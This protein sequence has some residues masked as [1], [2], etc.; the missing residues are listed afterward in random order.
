MNCEILTPSTGRVVPRSFQSKIQR[1]VCL[2]STP[3]LLLILGQLPAGSATISWTNTA[4]GAWEVAAN[5]DANRVPASSDD[6]VI[7]ANGNYT[8]TFNNVGDRYV[9]S[10]TIGGSSGKQQLITRLG[11]LVLGGPSFVNE[12]GV[13]SL[14]DNGLG[15][16]GSMTVN[17]VF[18]WNSGWIFIGNGLTIASSG[19]MNITNG[20]LGLSSVLKNHGIVNWYSGNPFVKNDGAGDNGAIWNEV[21]GVWNIFGDGSISRHH[22]AEQFHNAGLVRKMNSNGTSTFNIIFDNVGDVEAQSGV[23]RFGNGGSFGGHFVAEAGTSIGLPLLNFSASADGNVIAS[24]ISGNEAGST[25]VLSAIPGAGLPFSSWIVTNAGGS[26]ILSVIGNPAKFICGSSAANV[27]AHFG[28][29]STIMVDAGPGGSVHATPT[30]GP[31]GTTTT[32]L[33]TPSPGFAFLSW[34]P[35]NLGGGSISSTTANPVTFTFGISNANV[36]AN[37]SPVP[38]TKTG[39]VLPVSDFQRTTNATG[40]VLIIHGWTPPSLPLLFGSPYD[41]DAAMANL[42]IEIANRFVDDGKIGQWDVQLLDWSKGSIFNSQLTPTLAVMNAVKRG[43]KEANNIVV[44]GYSEVHL[45]GHSAGV[46]LADSIGKRLVAKGIPVNVTFLDAFVP[47]KFWFELSGPITNWLHDVYTPDKLGQGIPN[48]EHYVNMSD[49]SGTDEVLPNCVNFD[50]TCVKP[51]AYDSGDGHGWPVRWYR[52]TVANPNYPYGFYPAGVRVGFQDA[53]DI[54]GSKGS[55]NILP[56]GAA[57]ITVPN[58]TATPNGSVLVFTNLNTLSQGGDGN[59]A[60]ATNGARLFTTNYIWR[61]FDVD[62]TNSFNLGALSLAFSNHCNS[63]LGLW[64]DGSP[65][66]LIQSSISS[67]LNTLEVFPLPKAF[68][69]GAH[70]LGVSLESLDGE[71]VTVTVEAVGFYYTV[72]GPLVA[73]RALTPGKVEINWDAGEGLKYQVQYCDDLSTTNWL[74]LGPTVTAITNGVLSASENISTNTQR[75]YRVVVVP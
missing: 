42:Q 70:T 39:D 43:E 59:S 71:A 7:S 56:P 36:T 17:G 65:V 22:G 46:W 24:S 57:P 19:R 21:G 6:V 47:S 67:E 53:F 50:I 63:V 12:N 41:G 75:F 27:V 3:L 20:F 11:W 34:S 31:A 29:P 58:T 4:G 40:L 16:T 44:K 2:L 30:A 72:A 33:A 26:S 8:V 18:N 61:L 23:V 66:S 48:A 64:I 51:L 15:G 62:V 74:S 49:L 60:I 10:L 55:R 1:V 69:S 37:F 52:K 32:L 68:A 5:W 54:Q 35:N 28:Y 14:G 45:I 73:A 13:L 25:I 9:G 38:P